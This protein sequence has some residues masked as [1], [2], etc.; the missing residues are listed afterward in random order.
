MVAELHV[1]AKVKFSCLN[2]LP[3]KTEGL[4]S[5]SLRVGE[6]FLQTVFYMPFL[7]Y[8]L[9]VGSPVSLGAL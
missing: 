2:V 3:R 7:I 9:S 5:S 6:R 4:E 1:S 8:N